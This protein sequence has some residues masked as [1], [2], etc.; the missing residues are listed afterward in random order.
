MLQVFSKK[1]FKN[2]LHRLF[3]DRFFV[4][5][6][7]LLRSLYPLVNPFSGLRAS[8]FSGLQA[9]GFTLLRVKSFSGLR[10]SGL[11]DKSAKGFAGLQFCS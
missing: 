8:G 6:P 7:L 5:T 1:R 10:A 2:Y 3:F 11:A 9:F 4:Y